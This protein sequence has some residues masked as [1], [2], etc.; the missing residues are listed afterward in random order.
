M[1]VNCPQTLD[2]RQYCSYI[3]SNYNSMF[4]LLSLAFIL[5]RWLSMLDGTVQ[6]EGRCWLGVMSYPSTCMTP[7]ARYHAM[8]ARRGVLYSALMNNFSSSL[9][10]QQQSKLY[11]SLLR[12]LYGSS[13]P[14]NQSST[15]SRS[16]SC[17]TLI[18]LHDPARR[19]PEPG[20]RCFRHLGCA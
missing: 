2:S 4:S 10:Q 8:C 11:L 19:E 9:S 20:M 14:L 3:V 17:I 12:H 7:Y 1:L 5:S 15:A 18:L 6:N 16:R 13:H